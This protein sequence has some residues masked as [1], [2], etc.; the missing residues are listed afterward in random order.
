MGRRPLSRAPLAPRLS[1]LARGY[2]LRRRPQ[3][4]RAAAGRAI[5]V[6]TFTH[7]ANTCHSGLSRA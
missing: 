7:W 3:I 2:F 1:P 5:L 6:G 4:L